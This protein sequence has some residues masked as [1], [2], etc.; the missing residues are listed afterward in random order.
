MIID[1]F[2]RDTGSSEPQNVECHAGGL[3]KLKYT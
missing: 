3:S 2:L 1:D